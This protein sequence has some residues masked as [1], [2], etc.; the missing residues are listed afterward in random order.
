M[1]VNIFGELTLMKQFNIKPNYSDLSRR[2]GLDRHTIK[3]YYEEG[4]KIVKERKRKTSKYDAYEGEIVAVLKK[5]GVT[6]K[7]ALE[8][9]NE[10]QR[11]VSD[12]SGKFT[13]SS[14]KVEAA[15][16]K[17]YV[18]EH[19]CFFCWAQSKCK[20]P[21]TGWNLSGSLGPSPRCLRSGCL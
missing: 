13:T 21:E 8:F 3:K 10:Q 5:P 18:N 6:K 17:V 16:N 14:D 9:L 7:A 15:I 4:G 20:E 19:V 1:E 12:L 11:I 2:Y